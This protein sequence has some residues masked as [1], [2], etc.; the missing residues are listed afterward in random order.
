MDSLFKFLVNEGFFANDA[1]DLT[2]KWH[3][4]KASQ[5]NTKRLFAHWFSLH[6]YV[7]P[8]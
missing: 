4:V 6:H 2:W 3:V 5:A 7:N 1:F 8:D